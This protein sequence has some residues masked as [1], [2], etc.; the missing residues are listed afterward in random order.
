[1]VD[2]KEKQLAESDFKQ[3]GAYAPKEKENGQTSKHCYYK[4][5]FV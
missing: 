3:Q 5:P 1:M 2:R 4:A